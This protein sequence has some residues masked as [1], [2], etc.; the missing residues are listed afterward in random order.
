MSYALDKPLELV[1]VG[2]GGL[3]PKSVCTNNGPIRFS[4]L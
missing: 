1:K 3:G 4:Q 2:S